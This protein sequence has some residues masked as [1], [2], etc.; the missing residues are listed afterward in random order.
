MYVGN[1][2]EIRYLKLNVYRG[3][4]SNDYGIVKYVN[5]TDTVVFKKINHTSFSIADPYLT[6]ACSS[7]SSNFGYV[8]VYNYR[9]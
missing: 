2:T 8:Q 5:W 6:V 3:V 4:D 9:K 1:G 7:C